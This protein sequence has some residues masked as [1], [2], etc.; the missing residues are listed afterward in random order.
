MVLDRAGQLIGST[1]V[2]IE[3]AHTHPEDVVFDGG[4]AVVSNRRN[5]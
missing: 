5:V 3:L 4:V 2:D 1:V